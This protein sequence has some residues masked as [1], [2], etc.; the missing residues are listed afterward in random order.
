MNAHARLAE[1]VDRMDDRCRWSRIG[2]RGLEPVGQPAHPLANL[3]QVVEDAL[4]W[5][6]DP[7]KGGK[8]DEKSLQEAAVA[9]LASHLGVLTGI[10][11]EATGHSEF[12]DGQGRLWDVKSPVSPDRPGWV[13]DPGHHL[14][15][16]RDDLD[17]G[18]GILLDLSAL[19]KPDALALTAT[20][21][22][23]LSADE[24]GRLLI[25]AD[26]GILGG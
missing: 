4:T 25:L 17:N 10:E 9:V 24:Q 16:V 13:F 7:A 5:S 2:T 15:V 12:Q 18:E 19:R 6:Q 26:Q 14:Q 11:R 21:E 22:S 8:V 3:D 1:R 20:L 23:G